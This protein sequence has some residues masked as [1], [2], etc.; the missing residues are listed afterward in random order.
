M[1]KQVAA[2]EESS[3]PKASPTP[4]EEVEDG[5]GRD[6]SVLDELIDR[7][8]LPWLDVHLEVGPGDGDR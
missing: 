6:E 2:P 1:R 4:G 5:E 8:G 3:E 7:S